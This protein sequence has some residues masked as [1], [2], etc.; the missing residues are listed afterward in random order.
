MA[1]AL[2][3]MS[4]LVLAMCAFDLVLE[5]RFTRVAIPVFVSHEH[6]RVS[7]VV[8]FLYPLCYSDHRLS[9]VLDGLGIIC[10]AIANGSVILD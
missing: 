5:P 2:A 6:L 10:H 4:S 7:W 3:L 8:D 1:V 9:W